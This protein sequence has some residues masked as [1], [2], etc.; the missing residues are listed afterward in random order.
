MRSPEFSVLIGSNMGRGIRHHKGICLSVV[1][2]SS[3]VA[4]GN[5]LIINKQIYHI[6]IRN[7][8][9]LYIYDS[10]L[11]CLLTILDLRLLYSWSLY[12]W[13]LF[14]FF[15]FFDILISSCGQKLLGMRYNNKC[16]IAARMGGC[17]WKSCQG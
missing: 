17:Q 14:F 6:N 5:V 12:S 16:Q 11:Y 2:R 1:T 10:V 8:R 15:F 7:P 13:S 9:R 3:N 4:N